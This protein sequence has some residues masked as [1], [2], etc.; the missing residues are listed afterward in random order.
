MEYIISR[1][2]RITEAGFYHIIN[3]GVERRK[4]FVEWLKYF[5]DRIKVVNLKLEHMYGPKDDDSKFVT[6]IT[7]QMLNNISSIDLTEGTQKRDFIYIDDVVDAYMLMLEK[8][9]A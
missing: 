9:K 8:S 7:N 2:N 1:K 4:I 6:W 5:S 3:R